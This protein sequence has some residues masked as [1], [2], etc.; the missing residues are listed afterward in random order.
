MPLTARHLDRHPVKIDGPLPIAPYPLQPVILRW[1]TV[2]RSS[3]SRPYSPRCSLTRRSSVVFKS[4]Q[5]SI[6]MIQESCNGTTNIGSLPEDCCCLQTY[7]TYTNRH[8]F[9]LHSYTSDR[10]IQLDHLRSRNATRR[11]ARLYHGAYC[12]IAWRH[13]YRSTS[14]AC[15]CLR[16]YLRHSAHSSPVMA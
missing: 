3:I 5:A 14:D 10:P 15:R 12:P 13:V 6:F 16:S 4:R 1:R 7:L 11:T 9:S 2:R 8:V